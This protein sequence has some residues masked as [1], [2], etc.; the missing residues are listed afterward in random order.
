MTTSVLWRTRSSRD[1]NHVIQ[2]EYY[3]FILFIHLSIYLQISYLFYLINIYLNI[4]NHFYITIKLAYI[5]Y[6]FQDGNMIYSTDNLLYYRSVIYS[7]NSELLNKKRFWFVHGFS[8]TNED[9]EQQ[10]QQKWY[11]TFF[12]VVIVFKSF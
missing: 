1:A 12:Y 4:K 11:K 8:Q 7:R 10:Q 6:I 2:S 3:L 5:L 9:L